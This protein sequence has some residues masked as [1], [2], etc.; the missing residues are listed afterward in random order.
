M[1][2][3]QDSDPDYSIEKRRPEIQIAECQKFAVRRLFDCSNRKIKEDELI[4]M[5][6]LFVITRRR[7]QLLIATAR[8]DPLKLADHWSS[9]WKRWSSR[10]S[11]KW[12][13]LWRYTSNDHF[14]VRSMDSVRAEQG[15]S[16]LPLLI[17]FIERPNRR[18][19]FIPISI[20]HER[21][22]NHLR[23]F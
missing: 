4:K 18:F 9:S 5:I 16:V 17:L 11:F 20:A 23:S 22:S 19:S 14:G 13:R 1:I 21:L 7:R 3:L 6:I 8:S 12:F 2:L 15:D 10:R